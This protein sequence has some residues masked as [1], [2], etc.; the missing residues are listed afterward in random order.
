LK[1]LINH[2]QKILSVQVVVTIIEVGGASGNPSLIIPPLDN[3]RF[4]Y[5]L[6]RHEFNSIITIVFDSFRQISTPLLPLFL[7]NIH[8]LASNCVDVVIVVVP[9]QYNPPP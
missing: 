6:E 3:I 7:L 9:L 4:P 8:K 2:P 5:E 1:A